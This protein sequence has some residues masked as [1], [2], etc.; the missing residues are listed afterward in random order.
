MPFVLD[1]SVAL[2]WA[3]EDE[4]R[5]SASVAYQRIRTDE[6]I[7]PSL[8]W[9]ELRNALVIGERRKRITEDATAAFLGHV[10]RL[11]VTID[12]APEETAI[13]ALT[14][15]HRLGVYDAAYLQLAQRERIPLAT[16]DSRLMRAARA[17][18]VTL[19]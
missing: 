5:P 12:Y 4:W 14:R 8:W 18:K 13:L 15:R 11:R 17:E 6:A 3:F 16:F 19:V 7:V 2:A 10:S 9:F 1:A